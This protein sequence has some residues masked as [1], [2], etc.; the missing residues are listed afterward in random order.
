[1]YFCTSCIKDASDTGFQYTHDAVPFQARSC[2]QMR[3]LTSLNFIRN[4]EVYLMISPGGFLRSSLAGP[5][6]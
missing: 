2:H 1:M 6:S 4:S 5:L 3:I